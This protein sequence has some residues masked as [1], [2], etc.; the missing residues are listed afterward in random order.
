MQTKPIPKN[1]LSEILGLSF[2]QK[3]LSR[4]KANGDCLE[5]AGAKCKGYGA[6]VVRGKDG[7]TKMFRAN[8]IALVIFLGRDLKEGLYSLHTCHNGVCLKEEHLYEGTPKQNQDD[9][10]ARGLGQS[11]LTDTD[12]AAIRVKYASG[13]YS[14]PQLGLEYGVHRSTISQIVTGKVRK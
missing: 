1:W 3:F 13:K 5:W 9:R 10:A 8:R 11:T 6:C 14:Q 12:A 2:A 7:K 4:R